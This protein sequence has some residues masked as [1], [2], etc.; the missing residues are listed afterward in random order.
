[1]AHDAFI[2]FS[3]KD[4]DA[5]DKIRHGLETRGITCWM[6]SRDV[7]PGDDF[8]DSIV[9]ALEAAQVMVLVFSTNANNS[10]EVK[11]ELVLAGQYKMPVLPVRIENV[12]ASGAFRLQLTIRQ[13]LDLFEDWDTNLAKLADQISWLIESRPDRSNR[14]SPPAPVDVEVSFWNS[15]KD[16]EDPGEFDAYLQQFPQ[17]RFVVLAQ[18]RAE[19]L[20]R[21]MAEA[22]PASSA[23][24]ASQADISST[25]TVGA[26]AAKARFEA[27]GGD[28]ANV[29]DSRLNESQHPGTSGTEPIN[30]QG[31]SSAPSE[32]APPSSSD[33]GSSAWR[34]FFAR[35]YDLLWE[36]LLVIVIA[37]IILSVS[38][39]TFDL[40]FR[41][42]RANFMALMMICLPIS[43]VID[44][45][46]HSQVGNTPGKFLLGVN[47]FTSSGKPLTLAQ[48]LSRNISLWVRGVGL[49]IPLLSMICMTQQWF[50]LRKKQPASYDAAPQYKVHVKPLTGFKTTCF[51]FSYIALSLS[52]S[53]MQTLYIAD[54]APAPDPNSGRTSDS[55]KGGQPSQNVAEVSTESSVPAPSEAIPRPAIAPASAPES[56]SP[57]K[58]DEDCI[59]AMLMAAKHENLTTVMAAA[60]TIDSLPK[61]AHG[62]RTTARKLNTEGLATLVAA[63]PNRAVMLFRQ[64]AA[65]D[66][67]DQEVLGNLAISYSAAGDQIKAEETAALALYLNPRRTATWAPLAVALAKDHREDLAL[68]AMWLAYQF[69]G[70]KQKTL[71]FIHAKLASETD[72]AVAKM[73]TD[74][75]AWIEK[76]KI[77]DG[78]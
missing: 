62:D 57:C 49:G 28:G 67:R 42:D 76:N 43:L 24:D 59:E 73:Y 36:Q 38:M 74:S 65:S 21:R 31:P 52:F 6:S 30:S 22:V 60:A 78:F 68:E 75:A 71:D 15:I 61:P 63:D 2:S 54:A 34:R 4:C 48:Y 8:Q 16:S 45:V 70:D 51:I 10:D 1:M 47:V 26:I 14:S 13:Y 12:V 27:L 9:G 41:S 20:R 64:A 44:A 56:T 7:Q 29:T 55:R 19:V 35:I 72:P 40:W 53:Y 33:Q 77:P 32:H 5:A 58:T 39:P 46:L 66:P 18:R 3:S 50:K 23:M 37:F 69:S 25:E 11:K 17:G